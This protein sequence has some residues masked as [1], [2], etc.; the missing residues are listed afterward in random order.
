VHS[1]STSIVKAATEQATQLKEANTKLQK[2]NQEHRRAE[3]AA[4]QR[5][6][7]MDAQHQ[8]LAKQ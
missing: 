5:I 7:E 8:D 3:Q 6:V 2:A 4:K 1:E